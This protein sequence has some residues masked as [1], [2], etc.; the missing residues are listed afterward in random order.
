MMQKTDYGLILK[1]SLSFNEVLEKTKAILQEESFGVLTTIDVAQTFKK[2][3]D[4][5]YPQYVILGVCHPTSAFK[6]LE[7]DKQVGLLLPCNVIVYAENNQ[8]IVSA[9]RPTVALGIT[10]KE[11]LEQTAKDIEEKLIRVLAKL[12]II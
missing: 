2:K 8:T 5:E 10:K 7:A 11:D 3:L 4:I 6:A 12:E 1:T 9:I